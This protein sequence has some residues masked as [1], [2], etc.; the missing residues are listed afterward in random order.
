MPLVVDKKSS[1]FTDYE[2]YSTPSE[3]DARN[4]PS[5]TSRPV[6]WLQ[7]CLNITVLMP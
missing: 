1:A 7:E 2:F 4:E 6:V 3:V 5:D